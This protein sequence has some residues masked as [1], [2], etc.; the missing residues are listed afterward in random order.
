MSAAAGIVRRRSGT[1]LGR[2]G[3]WEMV[4]MMTLS[5]VCVF[6]VIR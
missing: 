3:P 1:S 6:E 5:R 4:M 2:L